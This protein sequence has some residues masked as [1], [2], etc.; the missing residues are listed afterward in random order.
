MV[1][2]LSENIVYNYIYIFFIFFGSEIVLGIVITH[3]RAKHK[4][5]KNRFSI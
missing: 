2:K 1:K 3:D 5:I 4:L